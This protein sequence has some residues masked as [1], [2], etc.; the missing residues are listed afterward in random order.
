M[1]GRQGEFMKQEEIGAES[2][3]EVGDVE[4]WKPGLYDTESKKRT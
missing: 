2:P 3:C 1:F 4:K